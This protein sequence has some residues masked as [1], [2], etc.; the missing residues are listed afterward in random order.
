MYS[1]HIIRHS[2]LSLWVSSSLYITFR[3]LSYIPFTPRT[4]EPNSYTYTAETYKIHQP[5]THTITP[6]GVIGVCVCQSGYKMWILVLEVS[7][8]MTHKSFTSVM[9]PTSTIHW[10]Q[11][12]EYHTKL[13]VFT[14][15]YVIYTVYK[16]CDPLCGHFQLHV[17]FWPLDWFRGCLIWSAT[18]NHADCHFGEG[19][20]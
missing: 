17:H 6:T 19:L 13:N 10:I 15:Y 14:I 3:M 18:A 9:E 5:S 8:S 12:Q 7:V 20:R 16:V 11:E 4:F 2:M 1:S